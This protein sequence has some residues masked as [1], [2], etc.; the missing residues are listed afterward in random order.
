MMR[1]NAVFIIMLMAILLVGCRYGEGEGNTI[2]DALLNV[3]EFSVLKMYEPVYVDENWTIL[4]F[5]G[6]L[7]DSEVDEI[8]VADIKGEHEKWLVTQIISLGEPSDEELNTARGG[9]NISAGFIHKSDS[10]KKDRQYVVE[11]DDLES[12]VRIDLISRTEQ[13]NINN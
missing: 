3:K 9:S 13:L 6:K 7:D 5:K 2:Y 4:V 11:L 8:F 1:I 10:K 12:N